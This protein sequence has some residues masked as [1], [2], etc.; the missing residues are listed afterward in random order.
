MSHR[1]RDCLER[2]CGLVSEIL[3]KDGQPIRTQ[4]LIEL[5]RETEPPPDIVRRVIE[6]L[7]DP[8]VMMR[9][10]RSLLD[11]FGRTVWRDG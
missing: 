6:R 9:F 8:P 11:Q 7:I 10:R 5:I 1:W 2:R 4:M 3:D